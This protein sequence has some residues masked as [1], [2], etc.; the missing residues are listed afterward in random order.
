MNYEER[1]EQNRGYRNFRT[2]LDF[3]MGFF[4][5]LIGFSVLYLK[6]FGAIELSNG[7]AYALGIMVVLY[8]VYRI[9]LGVRN[10]REQHNRKNADTR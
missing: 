5:I 9:V 6:Y 1:N 7:I 10:V 8:G 3:G 2:G 4:Y